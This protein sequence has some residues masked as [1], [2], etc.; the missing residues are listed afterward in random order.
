MARH[1][2]PPEPEEHGESAP[3]WIISF[4]D[5]VTLLMSFFVILAAGRPQDTATDPEFAR[6]VASIK[7]AFHNLPEAGA[8][9]DPRKDL[10]EILRKLTALLKKDERSRKVVRGDAREPGL[11]GK[12]FRV[13]RLRD[14]ME[15]T[16]GG[17]VFFDP[18]SAALTPEGREEV[19]ALG[20]AIRG[21]RNLIEVRGH[22]LE[23][24]A[25]QDWRYGDAMKLSYERA[26]GV[27]EEL[28]KAGIDPR[29]VRIVAA[30]PNEPLTR[31]VYDPARAGDN[32]RV[33]IL[34]REALLDD[35]TGAAR[36][37]RE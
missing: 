29:A 7:A 8:S 19:A 33:E 15:I 28:I 10:D 2:K 37:I 31:G 36:P 3:L 18:L 35:Y 16:V 24:S 32:R 13:R 27:A 22:A 23:E 5:L 6:V 20:Q 14:G 1:R 25:P 26:A 4:A 34:V 11:Y 12:S 17:P 9:A 30:G 21:H